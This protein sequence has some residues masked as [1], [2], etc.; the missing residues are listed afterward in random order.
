LVAALPDYPH[1]D[2]IAAPRL[3]EY[4]VGENPLRDELLT[5]PL[6]PVNGRLVVPEAPGLGIDLD[7]EAIKRYRVD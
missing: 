1:T 7:P 5:R 3:I 4:D 2:H 6:R